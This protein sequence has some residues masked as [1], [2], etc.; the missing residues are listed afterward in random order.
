[1]DTI[2]EVVTQGSIIDIMRTIIVSAIFVFASM[3][4]ERFMKNIFYYIRFLRNKRIY[5]GTKIHTDVNGTFDVIGEIVNV[6]L[7]RIDL[8]FG[9]DVASFSIARFM[10]KDW[11]II[12]GYKDII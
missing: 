12:D 2:I 7:S 6:K 5:I 4:A 9:D 1:M 3:Y 10:Q 8:R 11:V